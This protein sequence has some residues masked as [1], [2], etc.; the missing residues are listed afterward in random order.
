MSRKG[1]QYVVAIGMMLI[2]SPLVLQR[3]DVVMNDFTSGLMTGAGMGCVLL[4]LIKM[5]RST[6]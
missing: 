6:R 5:P 3:L 2:I 4:T 1:F